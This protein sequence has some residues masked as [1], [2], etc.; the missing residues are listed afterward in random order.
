MIV[1]KSTEKWFYQMTQDIRKLF[2]YRLTLL[3]RANEKDG[4]K[5]LMKVGHGLSLGEWRTLAV[6]R[7][8]QPCTL[9]SLAA[10][11]FLDEGQM[12]RMVKRLVEYKLIQR[13]ASSSD[14]R[15]LR[16]TLTSAGETL[17]QQVIETV[18][19]ANDK[20]L[21]VLSSHEGA[22]LLDML[23]RLLQ[24]IRDQEDSGQ[25]SMA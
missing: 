13:Q 18:V 8:L 22:A 23:D 25:T 6:I 4:Q 11:G 10:E 16:L 19:A 3:E 17:Y 9:R 14:R 1:Q 7:A 2:S 15:A 20:T 21:A 5:F 24:G 12:S